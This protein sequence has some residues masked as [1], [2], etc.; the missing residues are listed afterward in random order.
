MPNCIEPGALEKGLLRDQQGAWIPLLAAGLLGEVHQLSKKCQPVK[1]DT[2]LALHHK[3]QR[4]PEPTW[5]Q[6]H[7]VAAMPSLCEDLIACAWKKKSVLSSSFQVKRTQ[8]FG[9]NSH[10]REQTSTSK[11]YIFPKLLTNE[12]RLESSALEHNTHSS[13]CKAVSEVTSNSTES[14]TKSYNM[15]KFHAFNPP[16]FQPEHQPIAHRHS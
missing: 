2:L 11:F 13:F 12:F 9:L 15:C 14:Q 8:E 10:N 5:T 4:G 6:N 3:P 7:S 1:Y 16:T